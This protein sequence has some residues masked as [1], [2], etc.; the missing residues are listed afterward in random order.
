MNTFK[1]RLRYV[2]ETYIAVSEGGSF[3]AGITLEQVVN[4]S[5]ICLT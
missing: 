2:I 1:T 3:E 4:G 5:R